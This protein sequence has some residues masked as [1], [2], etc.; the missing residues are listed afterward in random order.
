MNRF[1]RFLAIFFV[2]LCLSGAAW[3]K[4]T[5]VIDAG[6]GGHDRGGVPGDRYAEKVYTLDVARRLQA[7]LRSMGFRTIMTRN[8]D[9]FVSLG[10]RCAIA[11]AQRNAIFVSIHFNSAPREGADGI[12]TYYYSRKSASL[13]S[14]VHRYV[15][16]AAGTEDRRVRSR[17]FYVVRNTRI[18]AILVECG[19]LTNRREG[20]RIAG[21]SAHRQRLADAIAMGIDRLY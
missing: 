8:G 16:R 5:V 13:A 17:G 19:F 20:S 21:S 6:H 1:A 18:P 4:P 10:G 2:L 14:S 11:N 9:Y 7:R 3:A 12:E 15:V